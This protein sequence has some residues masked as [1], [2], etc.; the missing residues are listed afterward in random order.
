MNI[1]ANGAE[2]RDYQN[3]A[4]LLD[5]LKIGLFYFVLHAVPGKRLECLTIMANPLP[6]V[7]RVEFPYGEY[8]GFD[9]VTGGSLGGSTP[10]E[11]IHNLNRELRP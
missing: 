8:L 10:K 3:S 5:F 11:P 2:K 9:E 4:F 7:Q 1:S 6:M